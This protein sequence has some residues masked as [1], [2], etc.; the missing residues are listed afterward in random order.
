MKWRRRVIRARESQWPN[1]SESKRSESNDVNHNSEGPRMKRVFAILL[2]CSASLILAGA[3]F[4]QADHSSAGNA[5]AQSATPASAAP[6]PVAPSSVAPSPQ[7]RAAAYTALGQLPDW[8]G[9]WT[10]DFP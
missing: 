4:A 6:S 8:S 3:C 5:P 7:Q 1:R 2:A 10:F 9:L